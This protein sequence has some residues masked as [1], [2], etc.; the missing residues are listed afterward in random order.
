MSSKVRF[1]HIKEPAALNGFCDRIRGARFIGFDTEFVSEDRY[2]PELCLLQIRGDDDMAIVDPLSCRDLTPFWELVTD[3]DAGHETVVHAAREEFRF[4]RNACGKR[5]ARLIDTQ[6]AA[7]LIGLEFPAAY[8]T[9]VSRLAGQSLSKHETRTNWR[10]RPLN[11]AQ[12]EY[13]IQDVMYLRPIHEELM[14]SIREL[15]RESWLS[16][17]MERQQSDFET[18]D[19]SERWERISGLKNMQPAQLAIVRELWRWRESIARECD[20]PARRI[21]RD[22]LIVELARRGTSQRDR[23]R[24]IRGMEYGRVQKYLAEISDAIERG[25]E[26]P[27]TKRPG[28][29]RGTRVPNLGLL[30]QFLSTALG[31]IC[32]DA[33]ISP[34]LAAS[35]EELRQVA[36]W[37]LEMIELKTPPRL[38]NGWRKEVVAEPIDEILEGRCSIRVSDPRANQPLE[39]K[40]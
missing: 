5:P 35:T 21:L 1:A 25:I 23:I 18:D 14:K 6:I 7:G 27:E 29:P 36:A 16:E 30:G 10:H 11:A 39:F 37:R 20:Q 4:C 33:S 34:N 31:I 24:S 13:A 19:A 2:L 3:E 8:S 32:R 26:T 17:E 38:L 28:K 40:R 12:L 22:D 15:D 9:L